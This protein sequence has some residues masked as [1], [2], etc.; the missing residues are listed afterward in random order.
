[1]TVVDSGQYQGAG[2]P[3]GAMVIW[4]NILQMFSSDN[5]NDVE[6]TVGYKLLRS[7][8]CYRGGLQKHFESP[9][10]REASVC[11]FRPLTA[12]RYSV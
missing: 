10:V 1:M 12:G 5:V 11:A 8:L 2:V 3:I 7:C 4:R 6:E 9:L